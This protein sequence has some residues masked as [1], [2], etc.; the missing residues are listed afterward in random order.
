[1]KDSPRVREIREALAKL[2][3]PEPIHLA[4]CPKCGGNA[5]LRCNLQDVGGNA[6]TQLDCLQIECGF[7]EVVPL[8]TAETFSTAHVSEQQLLGAND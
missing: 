4:K 5:Q 3:E 6:R 8:R 2:L 1:M 7:E